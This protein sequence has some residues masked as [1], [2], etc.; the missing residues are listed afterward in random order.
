MMLLLPNCIFRCGGAAVLLSN[1]SK[2]RS[3][4]KYE[5]VHT[6]RTHKAADEQAYQCAIQKEDGNGKLG[7]SLSKELTTVAG[8]ALKTKIVALAPLVLPLSEK[9]FYFVNFIRKKIS[10]MKLKPYNPD[11]KLAFEHFCIHSGGRAVL[12]AVEKNLQLTGW[13]LEPSMM[14]LYRF[15][16]TSSSSL[17]YELAYLEAKGRIRRGDRVW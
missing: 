11:F 8:D 17:W 15:G 2:D 14:S 3:W 4:S 7:V 9:F 5:L 1:K 6:V 10:K 13:H 12:D 16:N